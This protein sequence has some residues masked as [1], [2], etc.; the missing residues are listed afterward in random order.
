[1]SD[2]ARFKVL[3]GPIPVDLAEA[4]AGIAEL[5]PE[6]GGDDKVDGVLIYAKDESLPAFRRFRKDGGD[7]SIFALA[8][9]EVDLSARLRWIR[10]G[11]DDLVSLSTAPEILQRKL[12]APP[13]AAVDVAE[14]MSRGMFLDH[15]LRAMHRY[16]GARND[17]LAALGDGAITRYLDTCFL[18]DQVLRPRGSE[19]PAD[20]FGRRR[21][22]ARAEVHWPLQV[23]EP[24]QV[25]A[26]LLNFGADGM[27][28]AMG[29]APAEKLR[30]AI[31]AA[32]VGAVL[33]VDV[34]WQ[35]RVARDRWEV[36]VL[37]SAIAVV[38]GG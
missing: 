16:L 29:V 32:S 38:R 12:L 24:V 27:S 20:A 6:N 10:E 34:R 31:E 36:G 5:V 7:L 17:V 13:G 23:I 8:E 9:G 28:L 1:V 19:Q 37:V 22:G 2:L 30:V 33:D 25:A 3:G 4:L 15:Y 26:D 14:D 11:A 18:R 21:G 35:R